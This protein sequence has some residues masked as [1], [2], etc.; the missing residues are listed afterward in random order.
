[1]EDMRSL[2]ELQQEIWGYGLPDSDFPYPARALFAFSESGGLVAGAFLE[3]RAIGLA[4]AWPGIEDLSGRAYLHSQL[5]GVLPNYRHLGLGYHLKTYQRD[6]AN[7]AGL[8]LIKWTFDPLQSANANLNLRKLGAVATAFCPQ[9]YGELHSHFSAG[10]ATDRLTVEWHIHS[11]RTLSRLDSVPSLLAETPSLT[12]VTRVEPVGPEESGLRRLAHYE[13]SLVEPELLVEIPNDFD[14]FRSK[15][16][17]L[18]SDWQAKIRHL[19][20]HYFGCR[21]LISDF[22][23]LEGPRRRGFYLLSNR[24]LDDV[25]A[26]VLG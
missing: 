6:F 21:Y 15:E 26:G 5:V 9:Y 17:R 10:L 3:N 18:A 23:L 24:T 16:P 11:R 8:D 22:L 4:I 13:L 2:V 7:R 19:F 14:R 20:Q 25:L 1:M 12:A